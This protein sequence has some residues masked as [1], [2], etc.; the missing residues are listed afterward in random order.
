MFD[1]ILNYLDGKEFN[2][3]LKNDLFLKYIKTREL[4]TD[5]NTYEN[6]YLLFNRKKDLDMQRDC[7]GLILEKNTNKVVVACQRDFEETPQDKNDYISAEYCEDGTII[8]LYNH[9]NMWVTATKRCIDAKFSYW[10]NTKTFNDMFWEVFSHNNMDLS[11]L[12]KNCTYIFSLLHV[13]NILVVKHN[14]NALVYLGNINN[15]TYVTNDTGD[16]NIFSVNPNIKLPEK[17]NLT[18]DDLD[19]LDK[20]D[21]QYF[22]P[23][24][25]GI[26]IKYN[27]NKIYKYDFKE[28]TFMQKIRG[29]EPLIRNRYL[30]LLN[31]QESLNILIS[32]YQEHAF[33]FSM[34]HHNLIIICNEIYKLYRD[35]HVKHTIT[36]DE[37]HLYYRT[38]KQLHGQY[39][40]TK[41]PITKYD[42]FDKLKTYNIYILKK[43]LKW[44]N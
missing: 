14:E 39:K 2:D 22:N 30:E 13:E 16:F 28:F 35:F 23:T 32:Y 43:L 29:N 38:I 36:I 7:N 44:V 1:S 5:E 21:S 3:S 11:L 8:R 42:V 24:K 26:L 19:D 9:N 4:K 34:V 6:L 40:A 33:T 17:I 15:K 18:K 10:S 20:I 12:D 25:R 27:N 31:D 41:K 37:D